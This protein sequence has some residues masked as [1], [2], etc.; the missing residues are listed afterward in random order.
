MIMNW[1][2]IIIPIIACL[3]LFFVS[4]D[5]VQTG[6]PSF[7]SIWIYTNNSEHKVEVRQIFYS[8]Y[9]TFILEPTESYTLNA[10][11]EGKDNNDS[12]QSPYKS[13]ATLLIIDDIKAIFLTSGGIIDKENYVAEEVTTGI[14][15]WQ[16]TYTFT[17]AE[18]DALL[19]EHEQEQEPSE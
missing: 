14:G 6:H 3:Y 2:K 16:F 13:G 12:Y 5:N 18:I 19:A 15:G 7:Q 10:G 17:E 11:G 1:K 8:D 4:C 9:F